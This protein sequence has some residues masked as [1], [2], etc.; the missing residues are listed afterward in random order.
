MP[1]EGHTRIRRPS[2]DRE[3]ETLL[4][5]IVRYGKS[6]KDLKDRNMRDVLE[7]RDQ[8]SLRDKARNMEMNALI[9]V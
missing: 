8:T 7:S 4:K 5:L 2:S 1:K 3:T 6:W 9:Q